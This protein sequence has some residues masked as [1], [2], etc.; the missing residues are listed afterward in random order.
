MA[1]SIGFRP[2]CYMNKLLVIG[3]GSLGG[4][5]LKFLA[6]SHGPTEIIAAD[7]D[8]QNGL[9]KMNNV[10]LGAS[11][12]GFH[13]RMKFLKMDVNDI[14]ATTSVLRNEQP[15]VVVNSTTLQSWWVIGA[16]LREDIY[17]RLLEAGLGPWTPMHLTLTYKLMQAVRKSGIRTHVVSASFP[18]AVNCILS[19]LGLAPTVGIGNFDFLVPR[20]KKAVSDKLRIPMRNVNVFMVGH[21]YLDVRVE[22]FGSTGG[23]PYFLRIFVGDRDV[24][25]EVNAERMLL[26]PIPTPALT[27]SDTQVAS[28]AIK[29]ILAI[30]NDTGELTHAPGPLGLPGGY[31]VRLNADGVEVVVPTGLTLKQAIQINE[32]AQKYDGI[33][34]IEDD[35]SVVLTEKAHNIMDEM[36]H[37]DRRR[38]RITESEAAAQELRQLYKDF[39]VTNSKA[40]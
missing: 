15:D 33:E 9:Q 19:N 5:I 8:G 20:V 6:R 24:T 22:E 23:C 30:I 26:T 13:P 27:G 35:G 1:R 18:D 4:H 25:E 11:N 10:V 37:Y 31:P 2:E 3:L 17:I 21:H 14:D 28:S 29:N 40:S 12:M 32:E 38:F 34:R 7:F 39:A 16:Q 36:L